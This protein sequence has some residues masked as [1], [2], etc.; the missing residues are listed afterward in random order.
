MY[1]CKICGKSVAPRTAC[2]KIILVTRDVIYPFRK[3]D[4]KRGQIVN[5]PISYVDE[6]GKKKYR[7]PNDSGGR[8]KEIAMEVAACPNCAHKHEESIKSHIG[9]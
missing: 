6:K 1:R 8:G 4:P 2:H 5:R 7:Y 9:V 3:S